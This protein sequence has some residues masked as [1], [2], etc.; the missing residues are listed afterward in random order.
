MFRFVW[1]MALIWPILALADEPPSA[2]G[3][4]LKLYRSGKLPV[5]RQ[6]T[7]L[8]MICTRGNEHDLRV[9]WDKVLDRSAMTAAV[10]LKAMAGLVDAAVTRKVKPK[11]DLDGITSLIDSP[12]PAIQSA[13]VKLAAACGVAVAAPSCAACRSTR[14]PGGNCNWRPWRDLSRSETNRVGRRY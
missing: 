7:V 1:V 12:E 5:D 3:P 8:E 14:K 13:A 11:G 10:R 2:V 6:A 4:L 9:V